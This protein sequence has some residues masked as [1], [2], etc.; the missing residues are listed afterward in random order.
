MAVLEI[1]VVTL[2]QSSEKS[3]ILDAQ[4]VYRGVFSN[5]SCMH[6]ALKID[7]M[8]CCKSCR[9]VFLFESDVEEHI[10]ATE[11]REMREVYFD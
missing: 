8:Y 9:A 1:Q 10:V 3:S 2:K 6:Q 5:A 7:R 11:H 4:S